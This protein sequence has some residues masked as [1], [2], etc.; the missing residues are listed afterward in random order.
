MLYYKKVL[1]FVNCYD[2]PSLAM[3]EKL[4]PKLYNLLGGYYLN[5][6]SSNKL[7][8]CRTNQ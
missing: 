6:G 8:A 7:L 3:P 1:L 5:K 2:G 4:S